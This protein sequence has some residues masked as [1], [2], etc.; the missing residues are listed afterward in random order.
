MTKVNKHGHG[1]DPT[2]LFEK[3][4]PSV[5]MNPKDKQ[6]TKLKPKGSQEYCLKGDLQQNHFFHLTNK[7]SRDFAYTTALRFNI[8]I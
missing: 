4:A 2:Q 8:H 5:P 3:I 6:P 7:K 1:L